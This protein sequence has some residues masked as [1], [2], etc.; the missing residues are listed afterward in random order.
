MLYISRCVSG[1]RIFLSNILQSLRNNHHPYRLA[2]AVK[3]YVD[4]CCFTKFLAKFYGIV[5][6]E[7]HPVT[8]F[9]VTMSDI[10]GNFWEIEFMQ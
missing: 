2:L 4:L 7:R 1:S 5:Q 8:H 6:F 9:D 10:G 3:F